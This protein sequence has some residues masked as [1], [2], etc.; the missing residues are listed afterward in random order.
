VLNFSHTATDAKFA[1]PGISSSEYLD[2][3]GEKRI[4]GI[5]R[6]TIADS[7]SPYQLHIYETTAAPSDVNV[8]ATVPEPVN[9]AI[10]GMIATAL[11]ARRR[12]INR[13]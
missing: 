6:G 1:L 10:F 2:V 5:R 11:M 7:F 12:R 13:S 8:G 9:I 3:V 4:E